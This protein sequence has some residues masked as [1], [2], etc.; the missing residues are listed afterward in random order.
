[1]NNR[2]VSVTI[3]QQRLSPAAAELLVAVTVEHITP[4]TKVRGRLV[5]PRCPGITTLEIAYPLRLIGQ[6][7]AEF[8]F[9]VLVPEPNLWCAESPFEYVATVELW[10]DGERRESRDNAVRFL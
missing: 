1:M 8:Q 10:E 6:R 2:I 9:R 3:S 7:D 4:E 5:G